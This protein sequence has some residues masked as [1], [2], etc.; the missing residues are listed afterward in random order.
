MGFASVTVPFVCILRT[1]KGS[2]RSQERRKEETGMEDSSKLR[3]QY[4][5]KSETLQG[6]NFNCEITGNFNLRRLMFK[7]MLHIFA[8]FYILFFFYFFILPLFFSF[9]LLFVESEEKNRR[10]AFLLQQFTTLFNLDSL[11]YV[12]FII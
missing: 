5:N 11:G 7:L 9:S 1:G 4:E 8:F 10:Q 6:Q 3:N 12:V 2:Y